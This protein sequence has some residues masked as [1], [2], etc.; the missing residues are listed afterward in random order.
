MNSKIFAPVN[1]PCRFC[2]GTGVNRYGSCPCVCN[3]TGVLT[4]ARLADEQLALPGLDEPTTIR[5]EAGRE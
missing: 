2:N 3:G 1:V 4:V 5:D